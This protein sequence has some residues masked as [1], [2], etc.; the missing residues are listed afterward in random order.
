MVMATAGEEMAS[1]IAARTVMR[2]ADINRSTSLK[3]MTVDGDSYPPN[4]GSMLA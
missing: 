2:T 4:I 3:V 1:C